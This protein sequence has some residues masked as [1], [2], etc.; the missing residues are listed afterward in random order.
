MVEAAARAGMAAT[1]AMAAAAARA[2][3]EATRSAA[4]ATA[5]TGAEVAATSA[6]AAAAKEDTLRGR[7]VGGGYTSQRQVTRFTGGRRTL[8][9]RPRG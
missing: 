2:A 5:G 9:H 4:E 3:T 7:R 6:V 1:M 8:R